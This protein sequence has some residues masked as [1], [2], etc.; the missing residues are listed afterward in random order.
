MSEAEILRQVRL[1]AS[2]LGIVTLR[3]NVGVLRDRDGRYVHY[4]LGTGSSDLIGWKSVTITAEMLG[5]RHAVFVAIEVKAPGGRATDE[6]V[7]FLNQVKLAGGVAAIV[8]SAE[9]LNSL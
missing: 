9:E 6:Q 5:K 2:K 3:N 7:N 1:Q 4:G 8:R